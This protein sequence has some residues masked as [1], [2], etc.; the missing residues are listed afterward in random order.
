MEYF[1]LNGNTLVPIQNI[2]E[3][4]AGTVFLQAVETQVNTATPVQA[5]QPE[6]NIVHDPKVHVK[7]LVF[8]DLE[9]SGLPSP[10]QRVCITEL[11]MVAVDRQTFGNN[12][13]LPFR[14][15]NKFVQ[16]IKPEVY[17]HPMA[18]KTS[19]LDNKILEN[20]QVFKEVVPAVKAFLDSLPQPACLLAHNGDRF[21][22]P[23]LQDELTRAGALDILDVYCC[24][25][26]GAM[27]HILRDGAPTNK[28]GGNS[29]SLDALYK[30]LC[31]RRKN[32]HQAEQDCLDLMRVC[33]HD[34]QAFLDYVDSHAVS[35]A[36]RGSANKSA[37]RLSM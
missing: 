35:F 6:S 32:A 14:V 12:K 17:V 26:I 36:E 23:I 18:A 22:Y 3:D 9:T 1:I 20:Q 13:T 24:D 19:G 34:R 27:K 10:G 30:K 7:T 33:H 29:F 21:D 2:T 25:T 28:R 37:Q 16:C 4:A 31:G 8:F 11:A 5:T 15:V